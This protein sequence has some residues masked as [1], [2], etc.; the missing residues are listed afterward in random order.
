[1][2]PKF[3]NAPPFWRSTADEVAETLAGCAQPRVWQLG[4]SSGGRP[5]V[6]AAWGEQEARERRMPFTTALS[7]GEPH[8]YFG[9][10][11]RRR[12]VVLIAA[13][14]H[15][16]EIEGTVACL[17]L[18]RVLEDGHDLRGK[19]WPRLAELAA[20]CRLLVVPLMNPDGRE[21]A[22]IRSFV[23][24]E[25]DEL[26][27]YGIGQWRD[28]TLIHYAGPYHA[29]PLQSEQVA[30]MGGYFNDRGVNLMFDDFLGTQR[31]PE[32]EAFFALARDEA[33]DCVLNLH[34]CGSGPF[35]NPGDQFI[36]ASFRYRQTAFSEVVAAR[37]RRVG[38]RPQSN[39]PPE[40]D[41]GLSLYSAWYLVCG[42]LP[43][44]FEFPHGITT[45]PFTHDEILDI[46][47]ITFE[48]VLALGLEEGFRPQGW[49]WPRGGKE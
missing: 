22:R 26:G 15:G 27:Y 46:G 2:Q 39:R 35:F 47:L 13:T 40:R 43:L 44:T 16:H 18:A 37:L 34:S 31:C 21:R 6:A 11:P 12:P 14:V 42:A 28:G 48:E 17:N 23:G 7:L 38:L 20:R 9:A 36:P 3:L 49:K 8:S 33:P 32:T 24:C 45:K 4:V 10:E 30:Y 19:P 5:L 1:M 41:L 25:L 29:H